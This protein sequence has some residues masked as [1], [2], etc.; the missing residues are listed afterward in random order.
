VKPVITETGNT[1]QTNYPAANVFQ[2]YMNGSS[3]TGATSASYSTA[4]ALGSY[5][6]A[7]D[8]LG[9]RDTS[10]AF[11]LTGI[12]DPGVQNT[13]L[14]PNP[15]NGSFILE[16]HGVRGSTYT[17]TNALGEMIEQNLITGD[18][19]EIRLVNVPAGVYTLSMKGSRP[20]SFTVAR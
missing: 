8:S 16:S 14:Y 15:N 20:V 1:L 3:I 19:Q 7:T 9:C 12:F 4:G 5:V 13:K 10:A 6:V 17:I 18:K 11:N 2:W